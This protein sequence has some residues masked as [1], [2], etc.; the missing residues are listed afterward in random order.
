MINGRIRGIAGIVGCTNPKT[1]MDYTHINLSK[2]LIKRDVLV[3]TTGCATVAC[4]KQGFLHPKD[5]LEM[6]GPGLREVCETVGIP[7]ILACG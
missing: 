6:A 5:A 4:G 2:E 7:P 3:L 1:P